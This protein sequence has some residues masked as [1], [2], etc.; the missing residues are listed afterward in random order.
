MIKRVLMLLCP[1]SLWFVATAPMGYTAMFMLV[2]PIKG[3]SA[4]LM[5]KDWIDLLSAQWGHGEPPPGATRT[6]QFERLTIAKNHDS[7]SALFARHAADGKPFRELKLEITVSVGNVR[8]PI[9]RVKLT[10]VRITSYSTAASG[11]EGIV[12]ADSIAFSFETITW[13][14]IRYNSSG[15]QISGSAACFDLRTNT[16]CPPSF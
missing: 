5:H 7:T 8:K 12:P 16:S 15:D 3:E 11:N 14:N 2:D 6:P 1:I 9:S 13:I 4:D 10:G